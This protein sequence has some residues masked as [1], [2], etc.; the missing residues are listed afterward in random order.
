MKKTKGE[1]FI[2]NG[3][4]YVPDR[5][6]PIKKATKQVDEIM[7]QVV[8]DRGIYAAA[9]AETNRLIAEIE[10]DEGVR[11]VFSIEINRQANE[12]FQAYS[13]SQD[14]INRRGAEL[15]EDQRKSLRDLIAKSDYKIESQIGCDT[16]QSKGLKE[17]QANMKKFDEI[18]RTI[19]EAQKQG[20]PREITI[21]HGFGK[22]CTFNSGP[23]TMNAIPENQETTNTD[24]LFTISEGNEDN[25]NEDG[26]ENNHQLTMPIKIALCNWCAP[27]GVNPCDGCEDKIPRGMLG[28]LMCVRCDT[29][30]IHCRLCRLEKQLERLR[31]CDTS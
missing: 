23:V 11:R 2:E 18:E 21:Q 19:L 29:F 14:E 6:K 4:H 13:D 1:G 24:A 10:N 20:G 12:D 9:Q 26:D 3:P 31:K 27:P 7:E 22:Y 30:L 16:D 17:H 25:V 5:Q 8:I 15:E 28:H